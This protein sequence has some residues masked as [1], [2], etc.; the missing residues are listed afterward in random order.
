MFSLPV[1]LS[2]PMLTK[3]RKMKQVFLFVLLSVVL[4]S[5]DLFAPI[6]LTVP[7]TYDA[8]AFESNAATELVIVEQMAA[9]SSTLATGQDPSVSF[10]IDELGQLFLQ[11]SPSLSSQTNEAFTSRVDNWLVE[12]AASSG[13]SFDLQDAPQ[14][15]GGVQGGY[16]FDENGVEL[17]QIVEKGLY[18][19]VLYYQA[20]KVSFDPIDTATSDKL[21]ALFGAHPDFPNSYNSAIHPNADRF[22][23]GYAAGRD[24]DNALGYYSIMKDAFITLQAASVNTFDYAFEVDQSLQT[25]RYIWEVINA[26]STIH[27]LSLAADLLEGSAPSDQDL[28]EATR[29]IAEAA[30]FMYGYWKLPLGYR[31][32][33]DNQIES[34]LE[35]L[36]IPVD[37][38]SRMYE[39]AQEPA[40]TRSRLEDVVEELQVF[41]KFTDAEVLA[42]KKDWVAEQSR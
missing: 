13:N 12:I 42:F 9:L 4:T 26:A 38:T 21:L 11:G 2:P 1:S 5:C 20:M 27:N 10:T 36:L 29:R 34:I 33:R 7:D 19:S 8:T 23:A 30:G 17:S 31:S 32:L 35:K 37:A 24:Q 18:G 40:D 14:G 39:F 15:N 6:P 41:Y 22:M 16:L 25:I 28:A 3:P